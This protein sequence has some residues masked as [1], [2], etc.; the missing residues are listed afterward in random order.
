[1]NLRSTNQKTVRGGR[2]KRV[3]KKRDEK[4]RNEPRDPVDDSTVDQTAGEK[5]M[6]ALES[7]VGRM[8]SISSWMRRWEGRERPDLECVVGLG[9]SDGSVSFR[10]GKSAE[11]RSSLLLQ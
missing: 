8:V 7:L 10:S 11:G 5:R 2:D 3:E 6:M 4:E 9:G 1:L